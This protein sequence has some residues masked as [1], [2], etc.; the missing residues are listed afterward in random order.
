MG[1]LGV[2]VDVAAA[3]WLVGTLSAA[4]ASPFYGRAMDIFGARVSP[5]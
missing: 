3:F 2:P 1:R 5:T 4:V